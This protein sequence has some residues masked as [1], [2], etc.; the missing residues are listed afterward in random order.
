MC[1]IITRKSLHTLSLWS[2]PIIL[3]LRICSSS[4]RSSNLSVLVVAGSPDLTSTSLRLPISRF[5][6]TTHLL[7]NGLYFCGWSNR[8][9]NDQ[10]W[11]EKKKNK[12]THILKRGKNCRNIL[13]INI[14]MSNLQRSSICTQ[15]LLWK[16]NH[17][18][19]SLVSQTNFQWR[20]LQG[21]PYSSIW[22]E[23]KH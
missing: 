23:T 5:P 16:K 6:C 17:L 8:L 10:T 14:Y 11:W 15:Y 2:P 21:T 7:T 4:S 20:C 19:L 1:K 3:M 12:L 9:T 18:R 22:L 13:L